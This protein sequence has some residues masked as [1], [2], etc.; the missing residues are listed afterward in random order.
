MANFKNT[1][2]C[3]K[4]FGN[5]FGEQELLNSEAPEVK[6]LEKEDKEK[7]TTLASA[8]FG[9]RKA[10]VGPI[11]A[12]VG[13]MVTQEIVKAITKKY[14]PIKQEFYFDTLELYVQPPINLENSV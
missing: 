14:M 5:S 6:D 9:T 13:G 10:S 3:Y 11:S 7:F 8:F 2:I 1:S 4:L 12:F